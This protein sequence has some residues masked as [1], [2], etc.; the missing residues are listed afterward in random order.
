MLRL[1]QPS[2][3]QGSRTLIS[4]SENRLSRAARPT[5]SGYLPFLFQ[6]THRESNPD[7]QTAS[8]MSSRWTMSPSLFSGP[9]G[10]R[11]PIAWLQARRR[12]V[13][14]AA[15]LFPRR[16]V[17]ELNPAFLLTEEA[18]RRNTYRPIIQMIPDGIEPSLSWMSPRRLRRWTTG[19]CCSSSRGGSRTHKFTRLSTSPL[20]LFAYPAMRRRF[21]AQVAGPG[22]HPAGRAYETRLSTGSPASKSISDQGESR[23]PMPLFG[24]TF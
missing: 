16:S 19:S 6:W 12:T 8:L 3:R 22:S 4:T 10:S 23:T 9:P 20:F 24:T 11:T 13:G 18:C 1:D 5:V 14:P 21:A 17:R 15:R 2:G 7:F